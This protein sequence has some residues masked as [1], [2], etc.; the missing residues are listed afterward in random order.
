MHIMWSIIL[1]FMLS[2]HERLK[3]LCGYKGYTT[4]C[5]YTL[6]DWFGFERNFK[7]QRTWGMQLKLYSTYRQRLWS[8]HNYIIQK[9]ISM[10]HQH[11]NHTTHPIL[12]FYFHVFFCCCCWGFS[13]IL[14]PVMPYCLW[15]FYSSVF[16]LYY[17]FLI[18]LFCVSRNNLWW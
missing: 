10:C 17:N 1:S 14:S 5:W 12:I 2:N 13:Y 4:N 6:F 18:L 3:Q 15:P 9:L 16:C 8:I 11:L 7:T